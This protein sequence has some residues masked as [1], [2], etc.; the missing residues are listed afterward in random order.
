MDA[1]LQSDFGALPLVTSVKESQSDDKHIQKCFATWVKQSSSPARGLTWEQVHLA[2]NWINTRAF[3]IMQ[4]F[5]TQDVNALIPAA[6]MLNTGRPVDL[7]VE[8]STS[9]TEYTMQ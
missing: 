2:L 9:D 6:D 7:N 3:T 8:W 4:N 5:A 1:A